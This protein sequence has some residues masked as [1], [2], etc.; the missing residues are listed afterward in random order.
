MGRLVQSRRVFDTPAPLLLLASWKEA[1]V[2]EPMAP[3]PMI[4]IVGMVV[5]T[6]FHPVLIRNFERRKSA[7]PRTL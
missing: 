6:R 2:A 4:A 1:A 5:E 7:R 3:T